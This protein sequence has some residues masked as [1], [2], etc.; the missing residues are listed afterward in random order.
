[1]RTGWLQFVPL[2]DGFQKIQAGAKAQFCNG[3]LRHFRPA[4]GKSI[5]IDKNMCGLCPAIDA[6]IVGIIKLDGARECVFIPLYIVSGFAFVLNRLCLLDEC[7]SQAHYTMIKPKNPID[8]VVIGAGI[9]GL[10]A[11]RHAIRRGEQVLVIE[12]RQVGAGASGG[13]LGALMP[14]MP[15]SWN[16]KKQMQFEGLASLEDVIAELE[17]DTGIECGFHRCGRLMPLVHE[18]MRNIMGQRIA[19]ANEHWQDKFQMEMLDQP[20]QDWLSSNIA[21]YGA[22]FDSLSARV[23]PRKY[24]AALRAF[25]ESRASLLEG[26]EVVSVEPDANRVILKSGEIIHADRIV[27][28]NGWE[29]YPLLQP[30]MGSMNNDKSIGRGVKGQAVL[31]EYNHDDTLPI[32]YH[33]GTYVVP[34]AGNRVAIGSTSLRDWQESAYPEPDTFD[35]TDMEFYEKALQL[36]PVLRSAP[37]VERWAGVRPRNTLEG[38]GTE[39]FLGPV[40]GRENLFAL[41]GGFKITFGVAHVDWIGDFASRYGSPATSYPEQ[42]KS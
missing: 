11:A 20:L 8:C 19:G 22:S 42:F 26:K 2:P 25:I 33:D 37:I 15:D 10:W 34:H 7:L 35:P 4:G 40:P 38:R 3:A 13:F 24:L 18:G 41:V 9:L 31:V 12:K 36:V 29:A 14:H 1:M 39:P 27:V 32:V 16:A 21:Q 23:D 17:A 30:F 5:A 28:S 6:G